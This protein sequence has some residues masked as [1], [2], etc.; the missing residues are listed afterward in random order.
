MYPGATIVI[1][2]VPASV[3]NEFPPVVLGAW[4][5]GNPASVGSETTY[6]ATT[7]AGNL[8]TITLTRGAG[9]AST[10]LGRGFASNGW[11]ANATKAS[12]I[13]NNEYFEFVISS[14]TAYNFSISTLNATLRRS[15][16][17]APNAY[18]WR[19]S[20]DGNNFF[21]IGSDISYTGTTEGIAQAQISLAGIPA[22]QN[23]K[24]ATFRLYAWGGTSAT[25]TFSIGRFATGVTSNSLAIGGNVFA[26]ITP[27]TLTA[28]A[29]S[30]TVENSIDI[31]H[32]ADATW[33]SAI[34]AVKIGATALTP[35]TD[36]AITSGNIQLLP[37]GGNSLL[38]EAGTKAITIVAP[39]Y[40][41]ATL[42]QV[43]NAGVP[44]SNPT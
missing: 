36:Y 43:I 44:T 38:T 34:T 17:N 20:V 41:N 1:A 31:T 40:T 22:L 33:T 42:S 11:D 16:S 24:S 14:I 5:F 30:N 2:F 39:G 23:S 35:T 9:I 28:D 6:N 13:S 15:A 32:S 10:A 26:D 27:P 12:A 8:N 25:A 4:Q 37:S 19:Y 18:V 7:T 21:D 3:N 29:T